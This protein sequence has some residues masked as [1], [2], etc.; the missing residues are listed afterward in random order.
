MAK[1]NQGSAS[2]FKL[3]YAS[4]VTVRAPEFQPAASLQYV[5]AEALS[6]ASKARIDV[7]FFKAPCC[8][9]HVHAVIE[10]G[11]VVGLE[12]A[13]C[14]D[15][16]AAPPEAVAFVEAAL[17]RAG[18][19]TARKWKPIAVKDFFAS[20]AERVQ[21]ETNCIEFTFFGRTYFCCR[22]DNGPIGC[23]VV[24]PIRASRL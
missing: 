16:A 5:D 12:M 9:R 21:A 7:G 1:S 2:S 10:R 13:P 11:I 18:R 4:E 20:T 6:R 24:E 17:K 22:T 19:N 23:V 3:R 14:S 8:E 15:S